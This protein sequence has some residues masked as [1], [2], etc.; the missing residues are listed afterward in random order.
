MTHGSI[1]KPTPFPFSP[2]SVHPS[3][4]ALAEG[5][6][7]VYDPELHTGPAGA[8]SPMERA[9]RQE[10]AREVCATCPVL[11]R[12]LA[13]AL[14]AAPTAGVWAARTAQELTASAPA[15]LAEVA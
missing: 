15:A 13:Y 4:G 7:C 1:P 12:C 11:P 5:A 10:V 8:E 3:R 9:A 2:R 14:A 6:E